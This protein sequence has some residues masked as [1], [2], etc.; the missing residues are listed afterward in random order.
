MKL[1]YEKLKH[2]W[3]W[4]SLYTIQTPTLDLGIYEYV[5][6]KVYLEKVKDA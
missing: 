4:Q 3:V 6:V 5:R 1:R 2:L